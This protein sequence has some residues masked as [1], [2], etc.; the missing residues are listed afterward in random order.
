MSQRRTR[1][2]QKGSLPYA[3]RASARPMN[4]LTLTKILLD[5]VG[6]SLYAGTQL[7]FF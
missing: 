4:S 5:S 2:Y 7:E 3:S 6:S 1:I